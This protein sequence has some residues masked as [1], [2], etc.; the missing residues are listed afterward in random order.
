MRKHDGLRADQLIAEGYELQPD[1]RLRLRNSW[2]AQCK[3]CGLWFYRLK[4]NECWNCYD[5]AG[6]IAVR[7]VI[8]QDKSHEAE[9]KQKKKSRRKKR[10]T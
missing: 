2:K 10:R 3:R 8:K 1:G 5:N 4:G 9:K 7:T 6:R